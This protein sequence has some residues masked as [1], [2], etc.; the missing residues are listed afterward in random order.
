MQL[1]RSSNSPELNV[2]LGILVGLLL[3]D[4]SLSQK[5]NGYAIELSGKAEKLHA[6]FKAKMKRVFG[7]RDFTEM[8]DSRYP[9][10]KRTIVAEKTV[11]KRL[12]SVMPTYRTRQFEDGSFPVASLPEFIFKLPNA[13]L[14]KVLQVMFSC[15]G[16]I[17]LW[18]VWNKRWKLWEIKKWIKYACKHPTIRE[19]VYRLLVKLGY[20]PVVREQNDEILLTKK[21]DIIKFSRE[22]RFVDEVKVTKDSRNWEGF[23]KNTILDF[24]VKSYQIRQPKLK[25]FRTREALINFMKS[26]LAGEPSISDCKRPRVQVF[27]D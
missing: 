21:F 11:S 5:G 12:L 1:A 27:T 25:T 22:I 10:I 24:A 18:V 16:C 15:D 3:T 13:E 8:C 9:E 7:V 19:Q 4:G 2:D 17:S 14:A 23:E 6:I 26:T 20:Q